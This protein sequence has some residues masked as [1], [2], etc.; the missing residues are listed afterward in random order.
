MRWNFGVAVITSFLVSLLVSRLTHGG[1]GEVGRDIGNSARFLYLFVIGASLARYSTQARRLHEALPIVAKWSIVLTA[2]L[3]VGYST[4][5]FDFGYKNTI[6]EIGDIVLFAYCLHSQTC[7]RLLQTTVLVF[8]GRISYSLYLVHFPLL[9]LSV[10]LLAPYIPAWATVAFV[11]PAAVA[12]A[13]ILNRYVEIPANRFGR[14]LA[15]SNTTCAPTL[16]VS[17]SKVAPE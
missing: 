1:L 5:P 10:C 6:P 15:D 2:L 7:T 13:W 4:L 3:F 12:I 16:A 17:L 9:I 11:P 8:F 14:R